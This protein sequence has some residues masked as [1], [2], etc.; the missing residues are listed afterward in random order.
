MLDGDYCAYPPQIASDVEVTEQRD[1]DRMAY[2]VGSAAAGRY[3]LLRPT[4]HRVLQ[5][6]GESLAPATVCDEFKRKHGGTLSLPALTRFLATLDEIAIL[7]G[8]RS[9]SG[10]VP[11]HQSGRHSTSVSSSS[12]RIGSSRGWFRPCAG[13]GPRDLSSPLLYSCCQ[14]FCCLSEAGPK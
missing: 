8:E 4:E 13:S 11:N 1:G 10:A 14:R 7:A 5:L 9:Q 3:V 6:L 12:T 2:I